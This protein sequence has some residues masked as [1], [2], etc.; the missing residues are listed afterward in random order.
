MFSE[1]G[2][3]LDGLEGT[4]VDGI[5]DGSPRLG[6][7]ARGIDLDDMG[8]FPLEFRWLTRERRYLFNV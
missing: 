8:G 5:E 6:V 3:A 7:S 4:G 1:D 2:F